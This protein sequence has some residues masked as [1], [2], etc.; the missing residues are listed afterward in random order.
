MDRY[1]VNIEP[2]DPSGV[3][4]TVE[5]LPRLFIFA[6]TRGE[7]LRRAREAIAFQ[8]SVGVGAIDLPLVELVPRVSSRL[9]SSTS[10]SM[11]CVRLAMSSWRSA[12]K[13]CCTSSARA[14]V[15]S[16]TPEPSASDKHQDEKQSRRPDPPSVD[17]RCGRCGWR[18]KVYPG[19]YGGY[20][21]A[22]C[23][24]LQ[25]GWMPTD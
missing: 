12:S 1:F 7:A 2:C 4:L 9:P 17:G 3:V 25:W 18:G 14:R 15:V 21:C 5:G 13:P 16:G 8:L 20:R 11:R 22:V 19:R 24:G 10:S 6:E 23:F